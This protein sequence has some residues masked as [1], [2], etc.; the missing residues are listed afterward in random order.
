MAN[1]KLKV[2]KDG[3]DRNRFCGPSVIS[4]LTDLTSGEAARLIRKQTGRRF[5]TGTHTS[6]V[7]RAL[8]ACNIKA[9]SWQNPGVRFNR[10]TGPTLAGWLKMSKADRTSGRVFLIVAGWHWQLVS[11]RRYTCGRIRDIVSIKDKRV[12]RRARVAEVLEL[13]SDNVTYPSINVSKPKDPNASDRAK[14]YR[15][16]K[17]IGADL[18]VQRAYRD[19]FVYPPEDLPLLDP[20]DGDHHCQSW[21][22][23]LVM[24]KDYERIVRNH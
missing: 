1:I 19:L 5:I 22:E 14:V 4:A 15:I 17:K 6:E 24:L 7:L 20:Y 18:D 21:Q 9:T 23:A 10:T 16:A 2:I 12:K 11:G 8:G 3:K 13:T